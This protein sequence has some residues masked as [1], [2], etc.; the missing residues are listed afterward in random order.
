MLIQC[1]DCHAILSEA[2]VAN[3][4]CPHCS[5]CNF[6]ELA[7]DGT[8]VKPYRPTEAIGGCP[9]PETTPH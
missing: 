3:G 8:P 7:E 4:I 1:V 2:A 6:V 9:L 5:G